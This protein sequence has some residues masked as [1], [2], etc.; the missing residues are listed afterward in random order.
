MHDPVYRLGIAW[1]NVAY[2]Q[3]PHAGFFL[4]EGTKSFPRPAIALLPRPASG[5]AVAGG[6]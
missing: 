2:N 5:R 1:Q 3:P 4:G 6:R